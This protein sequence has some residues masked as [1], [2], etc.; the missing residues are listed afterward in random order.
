MGADYIRYL[1]EKVANIMLCWPL[2]IIVNEKQVVQGPF[3]STETKWQSLAKPML[4][5]SLGF[6][7]RTIARKLPIVSTWIVPGNCLVI[8]RFGEDQ[9]TLCYSN[10]LTV[11]VMKF[12]NLC[13][14]SDII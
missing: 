1:W 9:L 14:G 12:Q 5:N 4:L 13:S 7:Y 3:F 2:K 11:Q 6:Q 8:G 10:R